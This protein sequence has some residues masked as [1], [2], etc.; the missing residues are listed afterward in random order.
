MVNPEL[1]QKV[2]ELHWEVEA[3]QAQTRALKVSQ[4]TQ[5]LDMQA[6]ALSTQM[7]Y[8]KAK[9]RLYPLPFKIHV[10]ERLSD[11]IWVLIF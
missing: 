9:M 11:F 7:Q 5:L 4:D 8:E 2:Q 10:S 3:M 1:D 6:S